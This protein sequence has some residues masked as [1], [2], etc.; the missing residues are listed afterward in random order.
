MG[1]SPPTWVTSSLD[2]NRRRLDV[3]LDRFEMC[4]QLD[5]RDRLG[6]EPP[7][8]PLADLLLTKLQVVET[9]DKDFDHLHPSHIQRIYIDPASALP[10][11][12]RSTP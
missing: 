5:L 9:T 2:A 12:P 11:P 10:T 6:L 7:T 4:H 3:F 1:S 8:L